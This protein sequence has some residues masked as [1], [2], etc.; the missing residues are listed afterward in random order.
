[1]I[2]INS[3]F[4][5]FWVRSSLTRQ[6]PRRFLLA[7]LAVSVV[8]ALLGLSPEQVAQAAYGFTQAAILS[9]P[10]EVEN[11]A[12][13][14]G[15]YN[16]DGR[17]D[18]VV[19]GSTQAGVPQTQLYSYGGGTTFTLDAASTAA[20][21]D[22]TFAALAWGDFDRDADLDLFISGR[23][24][25]SVGVTKLFVNNAGVLSDSG[26]TFAALYGQGLSWG[27]ADWGDYNLDGDL[28]LL[29]T[30]INDEMMTQTLVL[31]N[32][33]PDLIT[34]DTIFTDIGAGLQGV[35]KSTANW[36]DY[37]K[38]GLLDVF[39]TGDSIL[40]GV[41]SKL[42]RNTGAG[43]SEVSTP[44]PGV[45]LGSS[46]WGDFDSNGYPDLLLAGLNSSLDP[47]AQVY[48]NVNGSFSLAQD[49]P[50]VSRAS[51]AWGDFDN[52]S[53]PAENDGRLD[54][55]VSGAVADTYAPSTV[56]Y[57]YDAA[58]DTDGDPL[59]LPFAASSAALTDFARGVL[60]PG[61]MDGD[62]D[63][64]L[65]SLGRNAAGVP[66]DAFYLNTANPGANL[67]PSAPVLNPVVLTQYA[68]T[69]QYKADLS[70]TAVTADDHTPLLGQS[71]NF[72]VN[73]EAGNAVAPAQA[74]ISTGA[75][76]LSGAG[77]AGS[78]T[79]S[80]IYVDRTPDTCPVYHWSAQ[81]IDAARA[82]SAFAAQG[83]FAA[84]TPPV[85]VDD[86][87]TLGVSQTV[88]IPL[89]D[90][91][92]DADQDSL[93]VVELV[94]P[95][96]TYPGLTLSIVGNQLHV[97]TPPTVPNPSLVVSVDYSVAD[98]C[99]LL[100]LGTPETATDIG[101]IV[102][103]ITATNTPPVA[104]D[105]TATTAE[106]TP[107]TGIDVLAND[108]DANGDTL[109]LDSVT[110]PAHGTAEIVGGMVNYTSAADYFGT[111]T[112]DYGISD[113]FGGTDTGTVTVTI[114][115]VDDAPRFPGT[116][117]YNYSQTINEDVPFTNPTGATD[118]EGETLSYT[119]GTAPAH[120][121]L[122]LT[123]ATGAFT[124]TPALNYFGSDTF[125][126]V[127]REAGAGGLTATAVWTITIDPVNDA[128]VANNQSL[129][130][131]EDGT[132]TGVVLNFSDVEGDPLTF[133]QVTDVQ[134]G[135]LTVDQ[136][137]GTF[138]YAPAANYNGPDSF[139]YFVNDGLLD[140]A[141][142]VVSI[143]VT[144]VNDA[145]VAVDDTG[146]E[147][148]ENTSLNLIDVLA[149]DSDVDGTTPTVQS[150]TQGA[151]GTVTL[152]GGQVFY[153]PVLDY[154]GPDTF[155]YTITDGSL[156]DVGTVSL[157]VLNLSDAPVLADIPDQVVVEDHVLTLTATA[158]DPSITET[159]TFTAEWLV[160]GVPQ[161]LP[162]DAAIDPATGVFT[163]NVV[164]GASLQSPYQFQVTVTDSEGLTDTDTFTV[165][166]TPDVDLVLTVDDS[167]DP[168]LTGT[169]LEYTLTLRNV[170][171][172][173]PASNVVVTAT[174]PAQ[175]TFLPV[176]SSS[177]CTVVGNVL[178]C[179]VGNL[180]PG[181]ARTLTVSASVVGNLTASISLQTVFT[182]ASDP[183]EATPSNNQVTERTVVSVI[184]SV[185]EGD[186]TPGN[187]W[188]VPI[189]STTPTNRTFMGE[190][191][192]QSV[193]LT[194][195]NLPQHLTATV[196]FDLFILRSWDGN[197]IYSPGRQTPLGI[198]EQIGAV[199]GPDLWELMVDNNLTL[200]HTSFA[201]WTT[202]QQAYPDSYPGGDYEG[203]TGS[204]E[205]G[206]LGYEFF[207]ITSM[208]TVYHFELTFLHTSDTLV[209]NFR[210][211]GLQSKED[212]A[213]GLDNVSVTV[214]AAQP[215]LYNIYMPVAVR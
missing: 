101:T 184:V 109:V 74:N 71:Y 121:T 68:L 166:V 132:R 122:N 113:G 212:E 20:L 76:L 104:V 131:P 64:D 181:S 200:V 58:A 88:D 151:H 103:E 170:D 27:S 119:V 23:D 7:A 95:V 84:N 108:T 168:V 90:D 210:D 105:D 40:V 72:Y 186:D 100:G 136:A 174:L 160:G 22:V 25:A 202:Q 2:T 177:E 193:V 206:T 173:N 17:L 66:D 106:D 81:S 150:V 37:D 11:A 14:L 4:P 30:G 129:T 204:V 79:F 56:L 128:P 35:Y 148:N 12:A 147:I 214:L 18:L 78:N 111:D 156:T 207:G 171:A 70:W 125:S 205:N 182:A 60:L 29:L 53:T 110:T 52:N 198:L 176:G 195:P 28:D 158:T 1:M 197:H 137:A 107:I 9:A 19:A 112:F 73:D 194:L 36:V 86:T 191:N 42:Y 55:V 143:T 96:P 138:D 117:P 3:R 116:P 153:T 185:Y 91:D 179:T 115:P 208:D 188:S 44:F 154:N 43:F 75:R 54:A 124:Y 135:V 211:L 123:A 139:S 77:N 213:W 102:I 87:A 164:E 175:L 10:N 127:A 169:V 163:W 93:T 183:T 39:L 189:T 41:V 161:A 6:A 114:T 46:A 120:G 82:A 134:H 203:R 155:T 63:L 13:A 180:E 85:A 16:G 187:E 48:R 149:N 50:G 89:V 57:R 32:D 62:G 146:I 98:P 196:S 61:D 69:G 152:N 192:N 165:T 140:S 215:T 59:T 94:D 83:T 209:L 38:D 33:G 118:V 144:P 145:P 8:C 201:N 67:A 172:N 34:G 15:D 92:L 45:M 133:T 26:I 126:I 130:L 190:F 21:P 80:A 65:I 142:A 49:L 141:T 31:R 162:V 99:G 47:I 24:A 51:V 167:P 5:R 199:I 97:V 159:F 157:T 178:T